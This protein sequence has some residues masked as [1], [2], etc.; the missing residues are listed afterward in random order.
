LPTKASSIT[1]GAVGKGYIGYY[2]G[3]AFGIPR[4]S[5]QKEL[6][7]IWLQYLGQPAVQPAWAVET[8]RIVHLSTFNDPLILAQDQQL[9]GYYTLMKRQGHLFAGA[10]P[11]PFHTEVRDAI[12]P[13]IHRAIRGELTPDEALDQAALAV[14]QVLIRLGYGRD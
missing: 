6:A 5:Q 4:N 7:L 11:F 14:D 12:T 9:D 8:S 13:Y 10:P 1:P 3:A 2:D